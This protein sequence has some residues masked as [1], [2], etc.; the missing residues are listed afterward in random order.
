M[1]QSWLVGVQGDF[2]FADITGNGAL[3]AATL[4]LALMA[5]VGL[6]PAPASAEVG[7]MTHFRYEA[8]TCTFGYPGNACVTAV[9]CMSEGG[10]CSGS[11]HR[12]GQS[13]PALR[14]RG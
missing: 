5:V 8:C 12:E 14:V 1:N 11:C 10:H 6:A 13:S 7:N 2:T 4:G 3:V 9:S